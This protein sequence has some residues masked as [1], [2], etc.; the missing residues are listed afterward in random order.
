MPRDWVAGEQGRC[1]DRAELFEQDRCAARQRAPDASSRPA[2]T[3]SF[4]CPLDP[5]VRPVGWGQD[6]EQIP[7]VL[8][9]RDRVREWELS[10]DG[11]VVAAAVSPARDVAG[12]G[13]VG[14]DPMRGPFR[15]PDALADVAKTDAGVSGDAHQHLGVVGQ[16]RPARSRVL[17]HASYHF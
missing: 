15:D 7:D 2:I 14:D 5:P 17:G 13:E 9:A 16:K 4:P 8:L 6:L 10:V 12:V 11:V 3:G 1:R